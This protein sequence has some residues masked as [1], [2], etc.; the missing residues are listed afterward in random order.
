MR[1][2]KANEEVEKARRRNLKHLPELASKVARWGVDHA[3]RLSQLIPEVPERLND[4]A[5]DNWEP[6]LSVADCVGGRWPH[7]AR[8]AAVVLD[9]EAG[10][11]DDDSAAV[12]LLSDSWQ[13]FEDKGVQRILS[14]E[15]VTALINLEER[16]WCEW[17]NGSPI[18]SNG[19]ARLFKQFPVTST[20]LRAEGGGR[21]KGYHKQS[22][23]DP[24]ERYVLGE[25][26][27]TRSHFPDSN[28][29]TVTNGR[30]QPKTDDLNRDKQGNLSRLKSGSNPQETAVCHGVTVEKGDSGHLPHD[31]MP[32]L[33]EFLDRSRTKTVEI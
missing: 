19:I 16:P 11:D 7:I 2:R 8:T 33:P 10:S 31:E 30:D 24:Y 15:L 4:R 1:R 28:R 3:A 25:K 12:M 17:R 20:D 18:T 6:L 27:N 5:A 23:N 22:L 21:G 26:T 14:S 13:V 29:D 9:N 32:E